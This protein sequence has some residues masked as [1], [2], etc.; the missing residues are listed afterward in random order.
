VV[1]VGA[2]LANGSAGDI[3]VAVNGVVKAGVIAVN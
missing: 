2:L 1:N 3:T